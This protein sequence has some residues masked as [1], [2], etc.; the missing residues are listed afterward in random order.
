MNFNLH[1][2]ELRSD[3]SMNDKNNLFEN[4]IPKS[5]IV[6]RILISFN[7][8]SEYILVL[9]RSFSRRSIPNDRHKKYVMGEVRF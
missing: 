8:F 3:H 1:F 6:K 7:C 4:Y 5:Y 9:N 2:C